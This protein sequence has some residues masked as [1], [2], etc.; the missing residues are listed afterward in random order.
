MNMSLS[1]FDDPGLT[2]REPGVRLSG[3]LDDF[4]AGTRVRLRITV[5]QATTDAISK[6]DKIVTAREFVVTAEEL[7]AGR[8]KESLEFDESCVVATAQAIVQW[9]KELTL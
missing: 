8:V 9:G 4:V 1:H 2:T 6:V 5:T 3:R 7:S